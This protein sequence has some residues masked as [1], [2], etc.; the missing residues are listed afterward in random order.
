MNWIKYFGS[1][2]EDKTSDIRNNLVQIRTGEGKSVGTGMIG[3]T[4]G[5]L[6]LIKA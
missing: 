5:L 6:Q 2:S 4:C 3:E 1:G